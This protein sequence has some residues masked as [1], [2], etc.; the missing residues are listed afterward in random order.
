ML[1]NSGLLTALANDFSYDSALVWMLEVWAQAGDVVIALS[2]SGNSRNLLQL[3]QWAR[4]LDVWVISLTGALGGELAGLSLVCF[5]VPSEDSLRVQ[6]G[7]ILLA[8]VLL[9]F[10]ESKMVG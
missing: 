5:R 4:E 10:L 2:T 6:E 9:D 8:H 3:A 7:Y 1:G